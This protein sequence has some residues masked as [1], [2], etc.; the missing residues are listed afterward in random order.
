RATKRAVREALPR[1]RYVHLATHGFFAPPELKSALDG[2]G[3]RGDSMGHEGLSGYHPLLLSGLVL[4]GA[5]REAKGGEEDGVLTALEASELNLS[6]CELAVL[7]ACQTA[8]GKD[9]GG[10]GLLGLQRA[11]QVAGCRSVVAS[12]WKVD[13]RATQ[14]LMT[15]FY[16]AYWDRKKVSRA[17]A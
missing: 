10:E 16:A 1:C 11:F 2:G 12:L 17:E 7:S 4:S 3:S 14:D 8:L 9:A 13:D 15:A 5:N 6:R